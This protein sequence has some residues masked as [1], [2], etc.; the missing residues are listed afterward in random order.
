MKMAT[1]SEYM[2]AETMDFFNL[3]SFMS[4]LHPE[5]P[6]QKYNGYTGVRTKLR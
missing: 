1:F 4:D 3:K 2:I 6:S 5:L